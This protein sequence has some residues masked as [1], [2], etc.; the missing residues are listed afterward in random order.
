M[1][2]SSAAPLA[3]TS[4]RF[5]IVSCRCCATGK[6]RS[7]PENE[8]VETLDTAGC[9]AAPK[10]HR[11]LSCLR[12]L[13]V[14]LSQ[15]ARLILSDHHDRRHPCLSSRVCVS[16]RPD[17]PCH[18]PRAR[19]V[20]L[21]ILTLTGRFPVAPKIVVNRSALVHVRGASLRGHTRGPHVAVQHRSSDCTPTSVLR[22]AVGLPERRLCSINEAPAPAG[23]S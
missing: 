15:Q 7:M 13:T 23:G 17:Q 16:L 3:V 4:W 20:R 21:K 6:C 9:C 1:P 14:A 2:L 12:S 18:N 19:L 8:A 22:Q 5:L 10:A 11:V